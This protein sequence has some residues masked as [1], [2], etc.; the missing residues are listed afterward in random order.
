MNTRGLVD[1]IVLGLALSAGVFNR[2]LFS[3]FILMALVTTAMTVPLLRWAQRRAARAAMLS[4][5]ST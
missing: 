5:V 4:T 1:L 3:A 2:E